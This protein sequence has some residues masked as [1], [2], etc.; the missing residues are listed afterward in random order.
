METEASAR[1]EAELQAYVSSEDA[2]VA[3]AGEEV[4]RAIEDWTGV[5]P[6]ALGIDATELARWAL[7]NSSYEMS[8]TYAFAEPD[9]DGYSVEGDVYFYVTAPD[10]GTVVNGISSLC[11]NELYDARGRGS[12]TPDEQALVEGR[13][14]A[15]R[16]EALTESSERFLYAV[17]E[18]SVDEDGNVLDLSFTSDVLNGLPL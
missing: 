15:L 8:D 16:S 7:E 4:S 9:A 12:L 11:Y 6:A 14:E 3:R 1:V 2:A 5:D 13:L 18:G 10:L 17:Y